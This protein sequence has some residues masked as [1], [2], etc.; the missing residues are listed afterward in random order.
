LGWLQEAKGLIINNCIHAVGGFN[1][2]AYV[3]GQ[4]TRLVDPRGLWGVALGWG[5]GAYLGYGGDLAEGIFYSPD[6]KSQDPNAGNSC[7]PVAPSKFGGWYSRSHGGG[8]GGGVNAQ[9]QVF[10]GNG[11]DAFFG[12]G[13]TFTVTAFGISVGIGFGEGG[14]GPITGITVGAGPGT[15]FGVSATTTQTRRPM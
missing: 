14:L 2:Y 13:G 15:P 3:K 12:D 9:V 10:F 7:K 8:I 4:P 1:T 11:T 5:V 6:A